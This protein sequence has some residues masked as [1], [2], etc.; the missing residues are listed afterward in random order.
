MSP[1]PSSTQH[2]LKIK[3][4]VH[5]FSTGFLTW[6]LPQEPVPELSHPLV[7]DPFPNTQ[8]HPHSTQLLAIHSGPIIRDQHLI[9]RSPCE[10]LV[11][12]HEACPQSPILWVE[13]TKGPQLY[14]L[15]LPSQPFRMLAALLWM[16]Y[17]H[18]LSMLWCLNLHTLRWDCT[19]AKQSAS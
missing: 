18:I 1:A 2:H 5:W 13:Q 17:F 15:V 3:T 4:W 6:P 14:S 7:E 19:S 10:E 12:C 9:L 8:P 16:Y 11:G